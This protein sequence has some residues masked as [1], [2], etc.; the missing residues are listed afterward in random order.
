MLI[1]ITV[2]KKLNIFLRVKI[3]FITISLGMFQ[4]YNL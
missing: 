2:T 3:L 4:R 1:V